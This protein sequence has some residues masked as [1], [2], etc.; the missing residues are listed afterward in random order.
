MVSSFWTV[1][2]TL[3]CAKETPTLRLAAEPLAETVPKPA[4]RLHRT[5]ASQKKRLGAETDACH[6]PFDP[7]ALAASKCFPRLEKA[8]LRPGATKRRAVK[9][10]EA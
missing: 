1:Q 4:K 8:L 9:R 5:E 6:H 2:G 7:E 3:P 10:A